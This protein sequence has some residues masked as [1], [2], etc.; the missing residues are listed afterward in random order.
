ME[1]IHISDILDKQICRINDC[2]NMC[3]D[4]SENECYDKFHIY[5]KDFENQSCSLHTIDTIVKTLLEHNM[6]NKWFIDDA[7]IDVISIEL[8]MDTDVICEIDDIRS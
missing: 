4:N 1:D 3:I 7:K 5:S 6:Y 8:N 2:P